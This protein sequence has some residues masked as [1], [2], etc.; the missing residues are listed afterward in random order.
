MMARQLEPE[1][2]A[3]VLNHLR[4]QGKISH[5]S[6]VINELTLN[7]YKR[8]VDVAFVTA[9]RFYAVEIKSAA[10]SLYRLQGQVEKYA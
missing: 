10:D 6:V 5:D 4:G 9:N 1:M 2:K 8:R 7:G 3:S